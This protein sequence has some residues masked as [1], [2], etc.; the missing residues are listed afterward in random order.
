MDSKKTIREYISPNVWVLFVGVIGFALGIAL[1]GVSGDVA[2][3]IMML[4]VI[5]LFMGLFVVLPGIFK[6]NGVLKSLEKSGKLEDAA[7]ELKGEDVNITCKN[8]VCCTEHFIFVKKGSFVR[9]YDDILW[10]HKQKFVRRLLFVPIHTAES[11]AIYMKK[12]KYVIDLGGKDKN[13]ELTELISEIYGHNS[14]VLVGY[15]AQNQK[16]YQQ[17]KKAK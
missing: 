14:A 3:V 8:K 9:S 1:I 11:L 17:L 12:G 13:D 15:S 5:P 4:T 10:I 7:K 6:T 16:A 2:F